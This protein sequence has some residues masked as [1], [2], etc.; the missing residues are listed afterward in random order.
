MDKKE[1]MDKMM[2]M[3]E[4]SLGEGYEVKKE[5]VL[6][7]NGVKKTGI[8]IRKGKEGS[9]FYLDEFFKKGMTEEKDI[10]ECV[11]MLLESGMGKNGPDVC[12]MFSET[13]LDWE[14]VREKVYPVLLPAEENR[15]LLKDL[16]WHPYLDLVA[17]CMIQLTEPEIGMANVKVTMA[18]RKLWGVEE[19]ILWEQAMENM[20]RECECYGMHEIFPEYFPCSGKEGGFRIL[21]NKVKSYGAA[22]VLDP[23]ILRRQSHGNNLFILPSSIHETLLMEDNGSLV[24]ED[25]DGLVKSVNREQVPREERLSDHCYYYDYAKN[26]VRTEK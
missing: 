14:S 18:L 17:L 15:E 6:K 11:K 4:G 3:L 21:S 16:V 7:N 12:K 26:E 13:V 19:E 22:C 24:K 10:Q 2:E 5:E 23:A 20:R 25:L 9:I 1:W 8:L